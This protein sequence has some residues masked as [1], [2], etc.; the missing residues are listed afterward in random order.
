M[1]KEETLTPLP[2]CISLSTRNAVLKAMTQIRAN[3]PQTVDAFISLLSSV[4]ADDTD[5]EVTVSEE[6]ERSRKAE[7]VRRMAEEQKRKEEEARKAAEE[8][9]RRKDAAEEE[10]K[11]KEEKENTRKAAKKNTWLWGL[12]G[13][14]AVVGIIIGVKNASP[15]QISSKTYTVNGVSFDM[16]MVKAGT[17]TMGATSE[18]EDPDDD[19]KPTHQ[20]TLT[21]DYYIGKTEVTQALWKAVMGNNPSDN[22]GDNLPV[23]SV[24][25]NDCKKFISKLNSLTGQNFRLPTEAE[26]E[27]AARGG[28]YSNHTQYSG[29][30]NLGDI[31]WYDNYNARPVAQKRPNELGIYDM[32]GNIEEW[33]NDY[34]GDYSSSSQT[35]PTG[36]NSGSLRVFRGGSYFY[37]PGFYRSSKRGNG[38]PDG[39]YSLT[40]LRL[41]LVP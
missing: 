22:K 1:A 12:V 34:Y 38:D 36:P 18:M 35:N 23:N 6:E 2:G 14:I 9:V 19:E 39:R 29:S 5:E 7:V 20:V 3:R 25:W 8:E 11:R 17:F 10:R 24:S 13:V 32:T 37:L 16:M 28:N 31:A 27:F 40:G 30:S 26:W 41:V 4:T 15:Q 21:N 33:C